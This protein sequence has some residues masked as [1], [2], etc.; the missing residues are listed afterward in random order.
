MYPPDTVKRECLEPC[1]SSVVAGMVGYEAIVQFWCVNVN[2]EYKYCRC[3]C[4]TRS[5]S[6]RCM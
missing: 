5:R 6:S 2:T 4:E 3:V 1:N